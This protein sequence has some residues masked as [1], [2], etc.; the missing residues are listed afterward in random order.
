MRDRLLQ[1]DYETQQLIRGLRRHR[2]ILTGGFLDGG[3]DAFKVFSD[4]VA[5]DL[6]ERLSRS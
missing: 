5:F 2:T 6:L 1:R 3:H 4:L